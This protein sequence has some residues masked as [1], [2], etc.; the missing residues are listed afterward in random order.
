VSGPSLQHSTPNPTLPS[1]SSSSSSSEAA[2]AFTQG[3]GGG[4]LPQQQQR[5]QQ[6]Q[7]AQ[8]FPSFF[9]FQSSVLPFQEPAQR[10]APVTEQQAVPP[11][12]SPAELV[13]ASSS[14]EQPPPPTPTFP[15]ADPFV[16]M[17][18]IQTGMFYCVRIK[19]CKW[20]KTDAHHCPLL[21][22]SLCFEAKATLD[23]SNAACYHS[24]VPSPSYLLSLL[25]LSR[26]LWSRSSL[27]C[28]MKC[29]GQL[30]G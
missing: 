1:S 7:Q 3:P 6:Q 20:Y 25:L 12:S 17:V 23:P 21:C 5:Q 11:F 2:T 4:S 22:S 9:P 18:W 8:R 16:G 13:V 10:Q 14:Q 15:L 19:S 26:S 30:V 24:L 29:L 27:A 28:L